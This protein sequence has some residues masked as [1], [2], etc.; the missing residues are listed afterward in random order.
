M[1][2]HE[3]VIAGGGVAGIEGLLRLSRLAGERVRITL[4]S[5]ED[6]F[7]YRPLAVLAPFTGETVRRYPLHELIADTGAHHVRDRLTHVDPGHRLIQTAEGHEYHYDALLVALGAGQTNPYAHATLFTDRNDGETFRSLLEDIDAQRVESVAFVVPNWPVWTLPLYELALLTADRAQAHQTPL[8][9]TFITA[10]PRPLKAFG[11]AASDALE[12]LLHDAGITLLTSEFADIPQ[13]GRLWLRHGEHHADRIITLPRLI[14]PAVHGLPAGTGWFTP[15]DEHCR[16]PGTEGRVFA[17]GD[18]ADFPVKH[19]GLG[20]QQAD[21]AAAGIAH[22]AGAAPRPN[23][24]TPIIRGL[25]LTPQKPLYLTATITHGLGWNSE[26]HDHC[27]WPN[28][29]KLTAE[30]LGPLLAKLTP[31]PALQ[32]AKETTATSSDMN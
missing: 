18:A 20:A 27:P 9:I 32:S 11:K 22:L 23:P 6:E 26:I 14:G 7:V 17:A 25:L 3:V 10:E 19:G 24:L 1:A 30:E 13:P 2:V 4:L 31:T 15:I 5:P 12:T 21:L 29:N 16:V 8:Q 28:D